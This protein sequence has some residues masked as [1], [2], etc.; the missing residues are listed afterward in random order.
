MSLNMLI[1]TGDGF[2]YTS[3]NFREWCSEASFR[4]FEFLPLTGSASAAIAYKV[5]VIAWSP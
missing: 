3:E 2:D 4:R 5:A 1:E